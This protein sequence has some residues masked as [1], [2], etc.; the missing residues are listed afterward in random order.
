[1]IKKQRKNKN[2][3]RK[4]KLKYDCLDINGYLL[5]KYFKNQELSENDY[6]N[7]LN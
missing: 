2:L 4:I 7:R 5:Y 1:M 3:K 6:F